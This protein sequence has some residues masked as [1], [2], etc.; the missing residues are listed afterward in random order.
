MTLFSLRPAYSR[1]FFKGFL[2]AA[3]V[4]LLPLSVHAQSLDNQALL[5]RIDRLE[6]D[7]RTLNRQIINAP[8]PA[9][10]ETSLPS[11]PQPSSG[12]P[13]IIYNSGESS[14]SRLMVRVTG[15]EQEVRNATGLAEN[16]AHT[17]DLVNARLD[18]LN[19][20]LNYRLSRLEGTAPGPSKIAQNSTLSSVPQVSTA[21]PY[22][23]VSQEGT[24]A[25]PT[26]GAPGYRHPKPAGSS[27][28]LGSVPQSILDQIVLQRKGDTTPG[29]TEKT[30]GT[31]PLSQ[32]ETPPLPNTAI[33]G[34]STKEQYKI[35]FNL[36]RQA[37]Y[38]EA[39]I[40]FKAFIT[41]NGDDPLVGNAHYWL[42]ETYYVRK[43]FMQAAQVFF[44]AYKKFPKGIKAA[45]SLLKLGMS[46]AAM[47]KTS[48]ACATFGKL[49]KEFGTDLKSNIERALNQETKRLACR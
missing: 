29:I 42:G 14:V 28:I 34:I 13:T 17:L 2:F 5:D 27:G 32:S 46:M 18:K 41:A 8:T 39:E 1:W 38:P 31:P 3:L 37:R 6:R 48:E 20:D 45:D 36:T 21:P 49:R 16:M 35:A 30:M 4:P 43:N 22:G 47:D 24:M 23:F 19:G 9:K 12:A 15:L 25:L 26:Q 10:T 33:S 7:I 40:A 44:Q 11:T